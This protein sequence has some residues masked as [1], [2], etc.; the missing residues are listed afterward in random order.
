MEFKDAIGCLKVLWFCGL[1]VGVLWFEGWGFMAL[2]C[3]SL[4]LFTIIT[5][6]MAVVDI[7]MC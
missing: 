3:V 4:R 5:S 6:Q 7:I 2:H 1:R